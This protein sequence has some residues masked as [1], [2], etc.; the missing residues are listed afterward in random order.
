MLPLLKTTINLEKSADYQRILVC[1][2]VSFFAVLVQSA[3]PLFFIGIGCVGLIV[4]C[5]QFFYLG[6]PDK[7]SQK[8]YR[9]GSYWYLQSKNKR[10]VR[11]EQLQLQFDGAFFLI[12]RLSGLGASK[13]LI[14][15]CDQLTVEQQHALRLINKIEKKEHRDV[16]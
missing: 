9:Q 15:F 13:R 7:K 6:Y 5:A 14:I 3:L 1:L 12:M 16:F 8:L 4:H 2:Y 11:Y 10:S